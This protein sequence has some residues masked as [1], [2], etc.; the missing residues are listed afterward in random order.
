MQ[1]SHYIYIIHG[2]Y[3]NQQHPSCSPVT[4]FTLSTAGIQTNNTHHE[5][6]S[7]Y[8]NYPLPVFKPTTLI[9]Q[10]SHSIYITLFWY[11]N[12]QHPSCS[13]VTLFK[14]STAG[15]QTKNTH[16]T[17]Q[18]L[19]LHYPLPVF[20]PTTPIM[21]SSHYI[22]ITHCRYSNQQH[23]SCSPVTLFKLHTAG[24]QTNNTHHAV[25]SLYLNYP[26]PVVKPKTPIKQSSHSIY[27]IHCRYSNQ[28]HQ[29]CS[30]VTIFTLHTV[31]I[32]INNTHHAVQSLYLHYSLPVFK[33]TTPIMQSS[34]H[35]Y[36]SHCRYSNHQHPSCT[37]GTL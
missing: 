29:S 9:M 12:Q 17:V 8:L 30:P 5:T 3:S 37:P 26:R 1:S 34:H 24:I 31:G 21:Q 14:L 13:P 16:Q 33:P 27:I 11:S 6:Q 15:S 36:I 19:N 18:P 28:Q 35:I 22:Y 32:L 4:L 7:L 23:P 10:C 25:Q 20:K 2:R